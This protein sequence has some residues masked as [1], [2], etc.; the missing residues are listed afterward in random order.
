MKKVTVCVTT[1]NEEDSIKD[2][3]DS[4]LKQSKKPDE[5]V[6]VDNKSTDRTVEIIRKFQKR[7]RTIKLIIKKSSRA[8]ARN[9][10]VKSSSSR[11]VA[12]TDA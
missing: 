3:L 7:T 10:A 2:L 1:F 8:E 11:V 9:I 12:M 6:I 5:I 4:L